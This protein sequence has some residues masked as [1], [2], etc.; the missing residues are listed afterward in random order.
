MFEDEGW[1]LETDNRTCNDLQAFCKLSYK[2]K[3]KGGGI[4]DATYCYS[5]IFLSVHF[6]A[7]SEDFK[8]I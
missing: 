5:C 2:P 1:G 6:L 3:N 7:W 8:C 4:N